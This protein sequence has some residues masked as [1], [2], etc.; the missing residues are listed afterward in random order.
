MPYGVVWRYKTPE[1]GH[2]IRLVSAP[3]SLEGVDSPDVAKQEGRTVLTELAPEQKVCITPLSVVEIDDHIMEKLQQCPILKLPTNDE[4][5][6]EEL[7]FVNVES[8]DAWT[9]ES[10]WQR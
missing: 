3:E 10:W 2:V 6:D 8:I 5:D 7:E 4:D 9:G 1:S